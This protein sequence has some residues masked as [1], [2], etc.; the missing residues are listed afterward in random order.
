MST[1]LQFW[2]ACY[3]DGKTGWDRGGVHPFM[4]HV[5]NECLL[6][7]CSVI[8][9]GCGRGYEVIDLAA[10]GFNV[11]GI[12]IADEPVQHLQR[13]LGGYEANSNVVKTNFFEYQ[14]ADQVDAVYE[15][16][17]LCAIDPSLRTQYEQT[18]F[19]WLKPDGRLFILFLQTAEKP[20]DVPPFHCALEEM[21]LLFPPPR[22]KWKAFEDAAKFEHPSGQLY[23][24]GFML[25]KSEVS[26]P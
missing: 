21:R 13:Q 24:L 20:N 12:D 15:Q 4:Q 3:A 7:S 9:P 11:I 26:V 6:E 5:L 18:V 22:W 2:N 19:S 14:P 10:R 25:T 1:N 17:C 23:E 8:V 16:T